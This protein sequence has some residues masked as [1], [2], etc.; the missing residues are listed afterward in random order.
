MLMPALTID[1]FDIGIY[2]QYA[3]RT[4]LM[5]QVLS[6]YHMRDATR[7]CPGADCRPL[8]K[9]CRTGSIAWHCYPG[10]SLG[11]FLCSSKLCDQRRSPFAFHRIFPIIGER[12]KEEGEEEPKAKRIFSKR[13]GCKTA[14]E[15]RRAKVL[16]ACFR[17]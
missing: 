7:A 10:R 11:L 13:S 8:P 17:R 5:E 15:E 16:K 3:R 12:E 1:Q 9:A 4:Q 2:I 14:E 6:Q